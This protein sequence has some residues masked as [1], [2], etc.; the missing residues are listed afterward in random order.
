MATDQKT[1]EYIAG[2]IQNAGE[3]TV[4][5]MFGEYAIY[6]NGK[7]FG[8]ICDNQLFLKPTEAGR[9][10]LG[11]PREA[12]AYPGSKNY[13]LLSEELEDVSRLSQLVRIS[14]AAL[15]DPKPKSA[16]Q[17]ATKGRTKK[18]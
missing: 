17:S 16:S 13:F 18:K 3:I 11:T 8:F 1:A 15:P 6:A 7:I 2:Q 9:A 4:R 12:Q 14:L 10:F 5:K